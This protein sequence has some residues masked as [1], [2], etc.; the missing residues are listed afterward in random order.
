MSIQDNRPRVAALS[1]AIG[2]PK[3]K[4]C[5]VITASVEPRSGKS[6][7]GNPEERLSS[8]RPRPGR[9]AGRVLDWV[10]EALALGISFVAVKLR[11]CPSGAPM[12]A[13]QGPCPPWPM[14]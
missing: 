13:A 12:N 5:C 4:T 3:F 14:A 2:K 7:C 11:D 6:G 9:Q 1:Y 8:T 10:F